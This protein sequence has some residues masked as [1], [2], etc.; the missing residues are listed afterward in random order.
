MQTSARLGGVVV[1][2]RWRGGV[3]AVRDGHCRRA[4]AKAAAPA[5]ALALALGSPAALA[6]GT[7]AGELWV[8]HPYAPPTP[9]AA[10]TAAVYLRTLAN[11]GAQPERL[12][13][14]QTPIAEAVEIH[15]STLDGDIM[16]MRAITAIDIAPG[17]ELRLRHGGEVHLM[18]VGLKTPLQEGQRFPLRLRFERAGEVEVTVW[19]QRPRG[20]AGHR[21]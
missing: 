1:S 16:R 18:L 11:R 20:D 3:A 8:D 21:H 14:G 7:R 10:R 2:A 17:A 15:R 6:H 5:L 12:L 4:W 9:A 19:V 13:G